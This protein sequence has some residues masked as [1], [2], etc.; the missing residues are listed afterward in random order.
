MI[1]C[2]DVS[3]DINDVSFD[4]NDVS[5]VFDNSTETTS[6]APQSTQVYSPSSSLGKRC[7]G[8]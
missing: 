6:P 3:F 7:Q 5:F 8:E 2:F 4:I 1:S